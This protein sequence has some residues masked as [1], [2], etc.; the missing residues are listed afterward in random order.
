[1]RAPDN[2]PRHAGSFARHVRHVGGAADTSDR[3][4][5]SMHLNFLSKLERR[6]ME[7]LARQVIEGG[8]VQSISKVGASSFTCCTFES[9]TR[10]TS[11]LSP[12]GQIYDQSLDFVAL[13]PRLFTLNYKNS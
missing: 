11:L 9:E 8:A 6:L 13:E 12:S 5:A 2:S 3:L 4:Y 10:L 7:D 1:M